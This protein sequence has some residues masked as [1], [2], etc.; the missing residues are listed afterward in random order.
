MSIDTLYLGGGTPSLLGAKN[1]TALIE[2]LNKTF[3]LTGLKEASIEVNPESAT[4][5]LLEA[6][7]NLGFSRVSCGVQSLS[8]YELKSVGRIHTAAQATAAIKLAQKSGFKAISADLMIGLPGQTSASLR[9][10]L[11]TLANLDIRHLSVYCLTVEEGTKLAKN[12]PADLPS[13]ETQATLFEET[14]GYL[15]SRGY[16][17]YE[18]SN[19]AFPGF[20]CLHNLNYWRGG[21]YPGLGPAAA[22]HIDSKRF[23]NYSNLDAYL[24]NPTGQIEYVEELSKKEKAAEEAMLRLRLLEEGLDA[25][26]LGRRFGE[27]NVEEVIARLEKL[28]QEGLLIKN[29]SRYRL[30]PARIMTSNPIFARVIAE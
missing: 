8:D 30:T 21:E 9:T 20:E 27:E 22:S 7:K 28:A 17:H 12:P 15:K 24:N 1:L 23:K 29:G 4:P 5:E 18:I 10:S 19:F 26:E 25:I 16:E 2:G 14:V 3:N 13:D 11:E 6:A